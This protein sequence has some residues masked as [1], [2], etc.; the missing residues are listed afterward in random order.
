MSRP[1][2]VWMRWKGRRTH[3]AD[4][5]IAMDRDWWLWSKFVLGG[6]FCFVCALRISWPPRGGGRDALAA[7]R[8]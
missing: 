4:Y 8:R 3:D 1:A 7:P 2:A 5:D 6:V